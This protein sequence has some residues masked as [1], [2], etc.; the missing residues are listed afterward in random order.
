MNTNA[1]GIGAVGIIIGLLLG[2]LAVPRI[3]PGMM[4]Y[5]DTYG[6]GGVVAENIDSIDRHFIEEMIPHHE[7][8]IAMAE[9]ARQ[10]S[11]RPEILSLSQDIIEAQTA[12]IDQMQAWYQDW[13]E[14][15]VPAY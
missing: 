2:S 15:A 3:F 7:G 10:M 1:L 6:G 5:G 4:G 11:K 12:E 14:R 9:L 13:F 8:A